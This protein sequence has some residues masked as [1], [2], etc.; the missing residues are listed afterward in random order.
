M[1]FQIFASRLK[2]LY[3]KIVWDI[4]VKIVWY[5][6]KGCRLC[7]AIVLKEIKKM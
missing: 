7:I 6:L 3:F 4:Y 2:D 1:K 5:L